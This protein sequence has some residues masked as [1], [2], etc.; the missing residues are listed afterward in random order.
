[1]LAPGIAR[2][3]RRRRT[4]RCKQSKNHRH[5]KQ[6]QD[7]A[8]EVAHV[9]RVRERLCRH[10]TGVNNARPHC[11]PYE[12]SV[13]EGIPRRYQQENSERGVNS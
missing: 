11:K 9:L 2:L 3:N 12:T 1:M 6:R 10:D 4:S 13:R 7:V 5:H 8:P